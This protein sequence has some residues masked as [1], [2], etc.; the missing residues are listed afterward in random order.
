MPP[1]F[2]PGR[3]PAGMPSAYPQFFSNP[4][5]PAFMP[6]LPQN[7]D[8]SPT[9]DE[10]TPQ[11]QYPPSGFP[12]PSLQG[13]KQNPYTGGYFVHPQYFHYGDVMQQYMQSLLK[14]QFQLQN[15]RAA[16]GASP[17]SEGN[18]ITIGRRRVK[19]G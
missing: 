7:A 14:Q 12:H 15:Y 18:T 2:E 11:S 13:M 10:S 17:A 1:T 8:G 6:H 5:V 4:F 9:E 16:K 3:L 19:I